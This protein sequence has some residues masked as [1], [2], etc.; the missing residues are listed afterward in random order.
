M[1][2]RMKNLS[3][4]LSDVKTR[5]IILGTLGV[6][7]VAVIIGVIGF[8]RKA[9]TVQSQASLQQAPQNIE[10]I[11]GLTPTSPEYTKLQQQLNVKRQ[12]QA[13]QTSQSFVPTVVNKAD[14]SA[15][16]GGGAS[17]LGLNND[18]PD[19]TAADSASLKAQMTA[20]QQQMTDQQQQLQ[21]LNNQ[22]LQQATQALQQS[23]TNE[24]QSLTAS[25]AG[26]TTA[27]QQS[28]VEGTAAKE[29]MQQ[30]QE[31]AAAA[32]ATPPSPPIIKA[33]TIL[34]ASL[35]TSVDSD[36]P[37]PV[38]A[39]I[40]AGDFYNTR[41]LGS[42]QQ[43]Q[44]VSGLNRPES[45]QLNFTTMSLPDKA[46]TITINAVAIDPDTARTALASDVDHHYMLRYGTMFA[47]AFLQGYGTAITQSGSTTTN[48]V[49]GGQTTQLQNL[50][51]WEEVA[52]GFGQVGQQWGN[53]L[54]QIFNRPNTITVNAGTSMGILFLSD[55]TLDAP[56]L[57]PK[58]S[59]S[60]TTTTSSTFSQKTSS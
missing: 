54:N 18:T 6:L 21:A 15:A 27:P 13:V 49:S 51:P 12:Q 20:I 17:M 47:S 9:D 31:E 7:F 29:I 46:T 41:L 5:T 1:A 16:A 44:D 14:T 60:S 39:T 22:Q 32:S 59:T 37:G 3:T 26:P 10:S 33:G 23:M 42:I 36:Q 19:T 43:T 24:A 48:F 45:V 55:V 25:W 11:P 34:F 50:K 40:V 53:Q 35:N 28:Y 56:S 52:A 2:S 8:N 57:A 4:A 30:E 38:L 58:L